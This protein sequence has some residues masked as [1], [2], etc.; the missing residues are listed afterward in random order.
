[1]GVAGALRAEL[2]KRRANRHVDTSTH[3][4]NSIVIYTVRDVRCFSNTSHSSAKPSRLDAWRERDAWTVPSCPRESDSEKVDKKPIITQTWNFFGWVGYLQN[5]NYSTVPTFPIRT[6]PFMLPRNSGGPRGRAVGQR[7]ALDMRKI[8]LAVLALVFVAYFAVVNMVFSLPPL[9]SAALDKN[10]GADG[11][12]VANTAGDG[13]YEPAAQAR[14]E[15][16]DALEA[17]KEAEKAETAAATATVTPTPEHSWVRNPHR[18][19]V[20]LDVAID[21]VFIGRVTAEVP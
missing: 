7:P 6:L 16:A 19:Y 12:V 9:P 5:P 13:D 3:S 17:E 14:E 21:D 2:D 15:L 10:G 8:I 1:M 18:Q 11:R 4:T 20:W